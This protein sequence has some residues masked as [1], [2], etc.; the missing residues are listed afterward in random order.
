[1]IEVRKTAA[2][3]EWLKGLKDVRAAARI[4]V[5][6]DR[7]E[8][9]NLGDA[10]FFDG[11]GEL[12]V[13]YGPGYRIYFVKRGNTVVILLCGGDKSSQNKDIKKAVTMAKEI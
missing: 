2:F 5:R 7:V 13:D 3:V 9:G 6:I 10:K 1:M 8:L 4:Q 12:R 11:I